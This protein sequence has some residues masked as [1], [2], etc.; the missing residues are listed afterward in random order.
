MDIDLVA[1]LAGRGHPGREPE[2]ALD[3]CPFDCER[4]PA[5]GECD[6]CLDCLYGPG[7]VD[8]PRPLGPRVV[9]AGPQVPLRHDELLEARGNLSISDVVGLVLRDHRGAQGWSQRELAAEIGWSK[10]AV[11]RVESDAGRMRLAAVVDVLLRCEHHLLVVPTG[12]TSHADGARWGYVDLLALDVR[13]RR[14]PP[15]ADVVVQ[16]DD[17]GAVVVSRRRRRGDAGP[18]AGTAR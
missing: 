2:Q 4:C 1:S 3:P 6:D 15:S 7:V 5:P 10:S 8:E 17:Y 13:G 9:R 11:A 16:R 14:P 12:G 18:R